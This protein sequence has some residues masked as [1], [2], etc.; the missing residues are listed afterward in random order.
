MM[1][2]S[3]IVF[4]ALSLLVSSFSLADGVEVKYIKSYDGDT[5]TV[6]L[7]ELEKLDKAGSYSL[8]WK[9]ISVRLGGIDTP[10]IKGACDAEK[11]LAKK[12]QTFVRNTLSSAQ[13]ITLD[14]HGRDKYFRILGELFADEVSLTQMLMD[15]GYAV[16]YDGG[17]KANVWCKSAPAKKLKR[18]PK[19]Y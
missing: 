19:A 7:P 5:V 9:N 12:A 11:E 1:R 3:P 18:S 2:H 8:F 13:T 16:P 14:I 4:F 17:T 6:N 15:K 10:E